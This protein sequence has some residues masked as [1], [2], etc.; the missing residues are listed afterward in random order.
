[1]HSIEELKKIAEEKKDEDKEKAPKEKTDREARKAELLKAKKTKKK[2]VGEGADAKEEEEETDELLFTEDEVHYVMYFMQDDVPEKEVLEEPFDPKKWL[3]LINRAKAYASRVN[4]KDAWRDSFVGG[5]RQVIGRGTKALLMGK[6]LKQ[7][8]PETGAVEEITVDPATVVGKTVVT[9]QVEPLT[10]KPKYEKTEV[11]VINIDSLSLT[12]QLEGLY[13]DK[14]VITINMANQYEMGGGWVKGRYAQEEMLMSRTSLSKSLSKEVNKDSK[15]EYPLS[16]FSC[17]A[18][19][20][21]TV[22]RKDEDEGMTFL[23][24][25]ERWTFN[26]LTVA[27]FDLNQKDKTLPPK[28]F[29]NEMLIGTRIKI[30]SMFALCA[31]EGMDILVLSALG[32]G[33]FKNPPE[34]VAAAFRAVIEQYAGYFS[35]IYFGIKGPKGKTNYNANVF[36]KVLLDKDVE[37][38]PETS[39]VVPAE[40]AFKAYERRSTEPPARTDVKKH[41]CIAAGECFIDDPDHYIEEAHP[42]QC[43]D[44]EHCERVDNEHKRLF[45]HK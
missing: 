42:P 34:L 24:P 18:T 16:D 9:D 5:I 32:C 39:K 17:V 23:K 45:T 19:H 6:T 33:S 29:T 25:E 15:V 35:H 22:L 1:M 8:N 20:G 4:K 10:V 21:V 31:N 14:N 2:I 43:P 7:V 38:V 12:R 36:T 26:V 11:C 3:D 37:D 27:G 30:E 44:G 28:P 40:L 41:I 13:P